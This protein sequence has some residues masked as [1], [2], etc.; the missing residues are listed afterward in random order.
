MTCKY[1]I[2]CLNVAFICLDAIIRDFYDLRVLKYCDLV[3][4]GLRNFIG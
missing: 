4:D 2:G 1:D 3:G